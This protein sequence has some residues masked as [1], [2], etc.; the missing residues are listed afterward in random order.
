M[1]AVPPLV[2]AVG[3]NVA[4]RVRPAP[5]IALRV[6]PVTATSPDA[7]FQVNVAPGSSLKVKVT[8][9]VSPIFS[10]DTSLVIASVG[11][12]VSIVTPRPD[13]ATE[14][15]PAGSVAFAVRVCPPADSVELVT[16]QL[17]PVAAAVPITVVPS[18]S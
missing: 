8:V 13:E 5:E 17:P 10:D 9:A 4:V 18:V 11:A 2:A 14:T 6:P 15:L 3:V 12:V 7:P 16:L 1:P